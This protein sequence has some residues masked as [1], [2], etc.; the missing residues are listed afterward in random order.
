VDA[1]SSLKT[2]FTLTVAVFL[3]LTV[4]GCELAKNQLEFDRAANK[5]LQDYR[6][7]F[8]PRKAPEE[9]KED[10]PDF[11][12]MVATPADLKL[13]SPL[14]TV[15]VNKTVSLRDLMFE[16]T[17]QAGVDIEMDPQIRG[18]IIFT[19]KDRPFNEVIERICTMTGLRYKF[20][21]NV[22]RIELDRPYVKNYKIEYM[23]MNRTSSS[24][25][26]NSIS[27][28]GDGS[29][30]TSTS[31]SSSGSSA[32]ISGTYTSSFWDDLDS[33]LANLLESSDQ[34]ISL[35]TMNDPAARAVATAQPVPTEENPNPAP[36]LAPPTLRVSNGSAEALVPNPEAT[37]SISKE[38]G[39]ITVFAN[40]RQHKLVKSYIDDLRKN[41]M[42]QIQIEAKILEVSLSDE[43]NTGIDWG[44]NAFGNMTISFPFTKTTSNTFT[45][46]V[47]LASFFKPLIQMLSE[48]GTVRALS[49]PRVT[50]LNSQPAVVNMT[51][52]VVYFSIEREQ[53]TS[54]SSG[55]SGDVIV[56]T[57]NSEAQTVAEGVLLNV[58]PTANVDTGEIIL[59]IRPTV[60]NITDQVEDPAN[61]GNYVPE[62]SV[63]EI[64]SIVRIQ[65]GQTVVMGGIMRDNNTVNQSG[66]PLIADIPVIGNF[67]SS[68]SDTIDK[69]ELV[70]LLQATLIP[71]ANADDT[72]RDMYKN[73]G[74][75]RHPIRF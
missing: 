66:V 53:S 69:T 48:Y 13:P 71:G 8:D 63:Q 40:E 21:D 15:S 5:S 44:D 4:S 1:K 36:N 74:L 56:E 58:L 50:V 9:A 7:M 65:S 34:Y 22:L 32:S 10:L 23:G 30:D 2:L 25:I 42:A 27:V 43:F 28:T 19:A 60:S 72:D 11:H 14:V 24:N 17:E 38:T 6:S 57:V 55:T 26:S 3:A 59:S 73:F 45:T 52:N 49:S 61:K 67:F 35:A 33:G 37:Y 16:L 20:K 47:S 64:D 41:V 29:G 70:I 18:S 46:N 51:K 12:P 54:S 62:V 31:S 75:D 68:H 39:I